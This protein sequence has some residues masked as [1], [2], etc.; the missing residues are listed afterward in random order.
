M[1]REFE[2]RAEKLG[3]STLDKE[4]ARYAEEMGLKLQLAYGLKCNL[5]KAW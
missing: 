3:H 1:V 5:H 2:E 4:A